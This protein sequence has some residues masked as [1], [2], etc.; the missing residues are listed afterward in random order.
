[1]MATT[2][3]HSIRKSNLLNGMIMFQCSPRRPK[4]RF[5]LRREVIITR[6]PNNDISFTKILGGALSANQILTQTDAKKRSSKEPLDQ[7]QKVVLQRI[8]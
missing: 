8:F 2:R 7:Y 3:L 5:G 4:L 6:F 1:M